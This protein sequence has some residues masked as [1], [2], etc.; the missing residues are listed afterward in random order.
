MKLN[1]LLLIGGFALFSVSCSVVAKNRINLT[2]PDARRATFR[3]GMLR[4]VLGN[5]K[6]AWKSRYFSLIRRISVKNALWFY[7]I[8]RMKTFFVL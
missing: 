4:A 6:R 3:F 7:N 5:G 2:L 8:R 1:A